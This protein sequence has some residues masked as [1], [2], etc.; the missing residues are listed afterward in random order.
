MRARSNATHGHGARGGTQP[1]T[2]RLNRET[3]SVTEPDELNTHRP[4][5]LFPFKT[6]RKDRLPSYDDRPNLCEKIAFAA[7]QVVAVAAIGLTACD[8]LKFTMLP[9]DAGVAGSSSNSIG[10]VALTNAPARPGAEPQPPY[11]QTAGLPGVQRSK[12]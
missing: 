2:A 1:P 11:Q 3:P 10:A 9:N 5:H 4:I 7:L 6:E 8:S 12:S